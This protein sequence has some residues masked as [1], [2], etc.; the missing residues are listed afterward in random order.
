MDSFDP[1]IRNLDAFDV[2]GSR[3]DGGVDL[4]ISCVGPL[5]ASV[6]TLRLL[7]QK[8]NA[9]LVAVAHENFSKV[10]PAASRGPVRIFV[11]CEHTVSSEARGVIGVLAAQASRSGIELLLV[12]HMV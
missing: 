12:K 7:Q 8:V 4:V 5:D 1:P 10:H 2:V 3:L 9:Y 6:E 11:S